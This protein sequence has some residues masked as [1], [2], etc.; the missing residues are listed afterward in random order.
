[1][2][3][4]FS[5]EPASGTTVE[6]REVLAVL[7]INRVSFTRDSYVKHVLLYTTFAIYNELRGEAYRL[8]IEPAV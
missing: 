2:V 5:G 3:C 8:T 6:K 1:M 4:A 7:V